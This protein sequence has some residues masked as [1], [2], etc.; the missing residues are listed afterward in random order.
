MLKEKNN[1]IL[2]LARESKEKKGER[3]KKTSNRW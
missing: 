3:E 1:Q 2:K